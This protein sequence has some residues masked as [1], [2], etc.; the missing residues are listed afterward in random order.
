VIVVLLRHAA[1]GD[2]HEW[3]GDDSLRPLDERGRRQAEALRERLLARGVTGVVSSPYTRCAETVAPL[4]TALGVELELDDRL[5]EGATRGDA[6][7]ALSSR[8]GFVACTHGDVVETVLGRS[9]KKG[10]AAV[11]ELDGG[12]AS[13]V[14]TLK[15]P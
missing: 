5:A 12:E 4:A 3:D 11:L 13:I 10:A 15:A 2:R 1:A 8:E 9:L 6:L 7:A 14:E